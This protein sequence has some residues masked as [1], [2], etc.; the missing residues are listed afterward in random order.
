[1][2]FIATFRFWSRPLTWAHF[3]PRVVHREMFHLEIKTY[4]KLSAGI[5][6]LNL[7]A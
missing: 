4:M 5:C 2:D 3:L 1:M 7:V 6:D